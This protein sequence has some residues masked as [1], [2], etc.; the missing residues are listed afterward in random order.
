M[1]YILYSL[2]IGR[3]SCH[4]FD[5]SVITRCIYITCWK[6]L[7]FAHILFMQVWFKNRRAKHRKLESQYP[8]QLLNPGL[9]AIGTRNPLSW[10]HQEYSIQENQQLPF[11]PNILLTRPPFPTYLDQSSPYCFSRPLQPLPTSP[12]VE[13]PRNRH[14]SSPCVQFTSLT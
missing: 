3:L 12:M 5:I 6:I 9:A 7:T 2:F 8:I 10:S 4:V 1:Q 11:R 13:I 14:W